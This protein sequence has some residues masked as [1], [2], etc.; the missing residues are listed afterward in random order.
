M[1]RINLHWLGWFRKPAKQ[2]SRLRGRMTAN[3]TSRL[4][5]I[6]H[7]FTSELKVALSD[8]SFSEHSEY[9]DNLGGLVIDSYR[10]EERVTCFGSYDHIQTLTY[11]GDSIVSKE[12]AIQDDPISSA[13]NYLNVLLKKS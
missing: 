8:H 13:I 11:I 12:F 3:N 10:G 4:R 2:D 7:A 6:F 5:Q 9:E 1:T